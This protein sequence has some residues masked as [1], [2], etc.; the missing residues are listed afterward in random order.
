VETWSAYEY[1]YLHLENVKRYGQICGLEALLTCGVDA[2]VEK[3][4]LELEKI[5]KEEGL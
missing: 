1:E 4:K 5:A 3:S 2:V